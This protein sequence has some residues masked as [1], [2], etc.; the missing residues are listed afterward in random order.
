MA[1]WIFSITCDLNKDLIRPAGDKRRSPERLERKKSY[2]T[3]EEK[4]PFFCYVVVAA[5]SASAS[6]VHADR[7]RCCC[8]RD[9]FLNGLSSIKSFLSYAAVWCVIP[10][11]PAEPL[12][13]WAR[14]LW[15]L[16][17]M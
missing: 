16:V 4:S 3:I 11:K 2:S 6:L 17:I 10:R 7:E 5:D 15:L 9:F 14:M 8:V 13:L 1:R 12:R